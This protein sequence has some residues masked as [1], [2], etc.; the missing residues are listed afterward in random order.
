MNAALPAPACDVADPWSR[1]NVDECAS[2]VIPPRLTYNVGC[3][4]SCLSGTGC[5]KRSSECRVRVRRCP[6]PGS[7]AACRR[8]H[9]CDSAARRPHSWQDVSSKDIGPSTNSGP[10][11]EE[12]PHIA[13]LLVPRLEKVL[14]RLIRQHHQLPIEDRIQQSR[15]T[16][17][18][19][20][21]S[22]LRLGHN[23]IHDA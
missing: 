9:G 13:K 5:V 1:C 23:F 12:L 21:R 11:I 7:A 4:A 18:V 22:T 3:Q 6:R 8:L 14:G 2:R 19:G 15:R 10:E 16:L 20:M 17:I